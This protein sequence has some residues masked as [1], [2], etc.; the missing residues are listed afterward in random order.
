MKVRGKTI[1]FV[2][3]KITTGEYAVIESNLPSKDA[4]IGIKLKFQFSANKMSK[5]ISVFSKFTFHFE[6]KEFIIIEGGCYFTIHSKDW[7][8]LLNDDKSELNVPKD[9]L[10]HLATLTV[11][12]TRGILHANTESTCFNDFHLPI[13]NLDNIVTSDTVFTL[14]K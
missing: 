8:A 9:F 2:L 12:T 3:S 6:E 7:N 11:G 1:G 13:I 4:E 14:N 5:T 10:C